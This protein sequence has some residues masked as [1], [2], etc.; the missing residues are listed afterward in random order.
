MK[1]FLWMKYFYVGDP[2]RCIGC[3]ECVAV[4]PVGVFIAK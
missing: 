2:L 4:C 3:M 1:K